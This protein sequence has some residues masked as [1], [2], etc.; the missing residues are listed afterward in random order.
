[1]VNYE[2]EEA[3]E[4]FIGIDKQGNYVFLDRVFKSREDFH[5]AV[6]TRMVPVSKEYVEERI[7]EIKD[8]EWSPLAHIYDEE[9]T[10]ESW[11]E[12]INN[13][14][15]WELEEMA[16]DSSYQGKYWN[17]TEEMAEKYYESEFYTTDCIGGGRMF[18][19]EMYDEDY[20]QYLENPDLLEMARRAESGLFFEG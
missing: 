8:Y 11:D 1:M 18:N 7:E 9:D 15:D 13:M 4:E 3:V 2:A 14:P 19:E 20:W 5:G 12:W 10:P 17:K 16:I 6:G